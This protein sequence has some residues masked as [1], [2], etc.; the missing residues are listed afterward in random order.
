MLSIISGIWIK[1]TLGFI[2]KK[3]KKAGKE[4][5]D[6]HAVSGKVEETRNERKINSQQR[7]RN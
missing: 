4:G 1:D 3:K 7:K 5:Y 2:C 6:C